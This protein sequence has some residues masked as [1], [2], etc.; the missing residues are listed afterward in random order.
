MS[1]RKVPTQRS[2]TAPANLFN[3]FLTRAVKNGELSVEHR[4]VLARQ[5]DNEVFV[6]KALVAMQRLAPE[7]KVVAASVELTS[8]YKRHGRCNLSDVAAQHLRSI[9]ELAAYTGSPEP[10]RRLPLPSIG[11]SALFGLLHAYSFQELSSSLSAA[12]GFG[13]GAASVAAGLSGQ[14]DSLRPRVKDAVDS[15]YSQSFSDVHAIALVA[16]INGNDAAIEVLTDVVRRRDAGGDFTSFSL[17]PLSQDSLSALEILR[18]ELSTDKDFSQ[19]SR[20]QLWAHS[21]WVASEGLGSWL[22]KHGSSPRAAAGVAAA[23]ETASYVVASASAS[24]QPSVRNAS[25][26]RLN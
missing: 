12:P 21:T 18:H 19:M 5:P 17:A 4:R 22:Q 14:A 2:V 25:A 3:E 10:G 13:F 26:P 8:G 20:E 15:V 9:P 7:A 16:A 1:N 11:S 6:R 23:L 24:L